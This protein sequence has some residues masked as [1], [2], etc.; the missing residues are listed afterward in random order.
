[1]SYKETFVWDVVVKA[2]A[3]K[4]GEQYSRWHIVYDDLHLNEVSRMRAEAKAL[5]RAKD[6]M[7][8][9]DGWGESR[10]DALENGD[11]KLTIRKRG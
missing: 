9:L 6:R 2:F 4:P 11:C 1:M 8:K 7:R 10:L 3:Q 5:R